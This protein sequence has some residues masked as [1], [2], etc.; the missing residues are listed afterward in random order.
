MTIY[1]YGRS[2][3]HWLLAL[4]IA[5]REIKFIDP[6]ESAM[7]VLCW[8]SANEFDVAFL[9]TAPVTIVEIDELHT[10]GEEDQVGKYLKDLPADRVFTADISMNESFRELV[11]RPWLVLSQGSNIEGIVTRDD[12]AKP[13]ASAFVLAHLI[14]LERTLR[15]L[16]GTYTNRPISDEPPED[17]PGQS[18]E[19][20]DERIKYLA[21]LFNKV[22]RV[23]LLVEE[24]GYTKKSTLR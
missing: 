7:D 2:P 1:D 15:R 10:C 22:V 21:D 19:V 5:S 6:T 4:D 20:R 16:Y 18:Q 17:M 11:K 23:D 24:L 9:Q 8:M 14:T 13:A 3:E 12:L